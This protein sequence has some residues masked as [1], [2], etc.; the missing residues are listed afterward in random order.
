MRVAIS[1]KGGSGKTTIAGLLARILARNGHKVLAIDAD[2]NPNMASAMG[3]PREDASEIHVIP[4]SVA[5]WLEDDNGQPSVHLEMPLD[6]IASEYGLN[7]PD[8]VRLLVTGQVSEAG[9]GCMCQPHTV[10]RGLMANMGDWADVT[11]TDME[12]GL[13]HLSRGTTEHADGMLVVLE[14]YFRSLDTGARAADLAKQLGIPNVWFIGNK[15]RTDLDRRA[16]AELAER[17]GFELLALIPYDEKLPEADQ[18]GMSPLDMA[19]GSPAV[20]EIRKLAET[21][22]TRLT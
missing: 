7:G 17:K 22:E 16:V 20:Q 19:P 8:G 4:R 3:V 2:P 13:E 15:I 21:L 6:Q 5:H 10:A 14:P 12:A 11:V 9:A 1:G 18:V